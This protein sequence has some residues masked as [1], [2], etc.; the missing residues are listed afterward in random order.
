MAKEKVK[1][2]QPEMRKVTKAKGSFQV[3][4]PKKFAKHYGVKAGDSVA[5]VPGAETISILPVRGD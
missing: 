2:L 5:L 3:N 4:I 1:K